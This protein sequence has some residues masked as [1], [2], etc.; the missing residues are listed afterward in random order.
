MIKYFS[1]IFLIVFIYPKNQNFDFVSNEELSDNYILIVDNRGF[2]KWNLKI[3]IIGNKDKAIVASNDETEYDKLAGADKG[4]DPMYSSD[5]N[6]PL[7]AQPGSNFTIKADLQSIQSL[8][9]ITEIKL[10]L[11]EKLPPRITIIIILM[12]I[13]N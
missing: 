9:E 12:E 10:F 4:L 1:L 6:S 7:K 2:G 11:E 5:N 3:N 13:V 8:G